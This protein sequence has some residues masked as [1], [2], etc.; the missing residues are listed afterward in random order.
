V[1]PTTHSSSSIQLHGRAE[2]ERPAVVYLVPRYPAISHTFVLREVE[3][4]RRLGRRVLT[5]S[6]HR[7]RAED[8]PAAVDLQANA[9]TY[10]L[11]P[12]R[13]RDHL[14]AHWGA[15]RTRP[16]RYFSTLAAA[17]RAGPVEPAVKARG[18]L[19]FCEGVVVWWH[20]HRSGACHIHGVFTGPAADAAML[21]ARLGGAGWSWSLAAHGT[22]MLQ[23][24]GPSLA[25]KIRSARFVT[26]SSDFGRSQLMALVEREY[27]SKIEVVHCGLD[28]AEY[29]GT[30]EPSTRG[31]ELR[32]L[33]V[34][35]LEREKGHALLLDALAAV[36]KHG[37]LRVALTVVGDGTQMPALRAQT[38]RLGI[39]D[40]VRFLGRIGQ[41]QIR[42][43]YAQA[44]V[45][46]LSSLGEGIPVVLMEA[47]ALRMPV[48]AP[49][50]MGIPELVEDGLS[51]V[52]VTPG[53]PDALAAAIGALAAQ[54]DRWPAMGEAGRAR[55]AEQ[56]EIAECARRLD[57]TLAQW[58]GTSAPALT[59]R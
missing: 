56:F 2:W 34:G 48:I 41:D 13:V 22:D 25:A 27:W 49:R 50:I 23:I 35:R 31:E 17:L 20:A 21:A 44:D 42:E 36:E 37:R 11:S 38:E 8:M 59:G 10:A 57:A 45:F 7:P 4:L 39:G 51:G 40:R 1:P 9:T 29:D 54:R 15:L 58:L 5:I 12:P 46:C 18:V 28:M 52:L 3:A 24:P 32:L 47:M 14:A 16:G 55:V 30:P 6:I 33:T 53:R 19:Y 43:H 26:V